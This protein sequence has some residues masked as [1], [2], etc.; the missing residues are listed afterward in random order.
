MTT[1]LV[2]YIGGTIY[3]SLVSFFF[4]DF[5]LICTTYLEGND[6]HLSAFV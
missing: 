4:F 6:F 2:F 1:S 5:I 3:V